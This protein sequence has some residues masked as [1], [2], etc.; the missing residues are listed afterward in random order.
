MHTAPGRSDTRTIARPDCR[1]DLR[2]A[3]P[4]SI[5]GLIAALSAE[6]YVSADAV[7]EAVNTG[8]SFNIIHIG[9]AV[10]VDVFISAD[11]FDQERL[12]RRQQVLIPAGTDV[13]ALFVDTPEDTVLRK[14]EWFRRGGEAS[15]RQWRDVIAVLRA[16]AG[17]L[18]DRHLREWS[19]RLGVADLL[20][21]ATA[22]AAR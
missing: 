16:Q 3:A 5:A 12:K 22:E 6:C 10:K 19:D 13:V 2:R 1:C 9:T 14:L 15:E 17:R 21:R 20:D 7:R 11:A 4:R 18:D 8:G